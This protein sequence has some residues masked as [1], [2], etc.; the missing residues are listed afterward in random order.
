MESLSN[1]VKDVTLPSLSRKR[2]M[3]GLFTPVVFERCL[4]VTHTRSKH[5]SIQMSSDLLAE[6]FGFYFLYLLSSIFS[7]QIHGKSLRHS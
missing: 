3:W 7:W 1:V 5:R 4:G 2:I 6:L